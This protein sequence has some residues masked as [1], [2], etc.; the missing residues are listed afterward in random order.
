MKV[1]EIVFFILIII[2]IYPGI[3]YLKKASIKPRKAGSDTDP[4][5]CYNG[6]KY[7]TAKKIWSDDG[8]CVYKFGG[9]NPVPVLGSSI[10]RIYTYEQ[11]GVSQKTDDNGNYNLLSNFSYV[12]PNINTAFDDFV[13]GNSHLSGKLSDI[14]NNTAG[15]CVDAD[16]LN[17]KYATKTCTEPNK[18]NS[19]N[20]CYNNK[21]IVVNSGDRKSVV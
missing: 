18:K 1:L 15:D 9:D 2:M 10:C 19:Q 8:T 11:A 12:K 14:N 7:Y 3:N 4:G 17:V 5:T 13:N 20:K 16:Q 6:S 21:G